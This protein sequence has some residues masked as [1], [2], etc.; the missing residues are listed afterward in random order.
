MIHLNFLIFHGKSEK[1]SQHKVP[2]SFLDCD[3]LYCGLGRGVVGSEGF[4]RF[5]SPHSLV[6]SD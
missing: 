4:S 6:G 2:H 5:P 1:S 3:F